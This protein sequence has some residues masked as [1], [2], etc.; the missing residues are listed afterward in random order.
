MSTNPGAVVG[1]V[2]AVDPAVAALIAGGRAAT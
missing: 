1:A 2:G